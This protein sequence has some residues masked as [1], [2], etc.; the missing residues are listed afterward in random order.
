MHIA[1]FKRLDYR[2]EFKVIEIAR[3]QHVEVRILCHACIDKFFDVSSH[4]QAFGLGFEGHRLF[5][6]VQAVITAFGIEMVRDNQYI[7]AIE[8]EFSGQRFARVVVQRIRGVNATRIQGKM[9]VFPFVGVI[10]L[11]DLAGF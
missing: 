10:G 3:K 9:A 6:A 7:L 2:A 11:A 1:A 8:G 4:L 5:L